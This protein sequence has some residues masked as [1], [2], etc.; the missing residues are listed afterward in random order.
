MKPESKTYT[1]NVGN[2]AVTFETGK[3]AGQAGGAVTVRLG[4]SIV[5]ASAT[6]GDVREGIYG[7]ADLFK[8]EF[9]P[10]PAAVSKAVCTAP[11]GEENAV[12]SARGSA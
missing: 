4:D 9:A 1:A 2:A 6:M 12:S 8:V 10:G 7:D 3:L 11:E 5:F